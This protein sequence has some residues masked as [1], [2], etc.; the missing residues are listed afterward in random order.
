MSRSTLLTIA[1]FFSAICGLC[2]CSA[3]DAAQDPDASTLDATLD[4][5]VPGCASIDDFC[6]SRLPG[7]ICPTTLD[8]ADDAGT[9]SGTGN[10]TIYQSTNM[11]GGND[12][13]EAGTLLD[14]GDVLLDIAGVDT[15]LLLF[16]DSTS[17]QLVGAQYVSNQIQEQCW[18]TVP[19]NF[20]E[21]VTDGGGC[22]NW[23]TG[24]LFGTFDAGVCYPLSGGNSD[25]GDAGDAPDSAAAGH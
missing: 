11:C 21:L 6:A 25:A 8:L 2:A 7:S 19:P 24:T 22:C 16:Y 9:W 12:V 13:S 5:T 18:G 4:G 10:C 14:A 17:R 23:Y 3:D 15:G 20:C 1:L